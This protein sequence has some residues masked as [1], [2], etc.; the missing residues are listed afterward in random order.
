MLPKELGMLPRNMLWSI[1][2]SSK[3][4]Q[5]PKVLGISPD[6]LFDE[7]SMYMSCVAL[8]TSAGSCPSRLLN[9]NP[10][11]GWNLKDLAWYPTLKIITRKA[12][13]C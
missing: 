3:L 4:S 7:T 10:I 9:D 2:M 5:L 1:S 12:E 11:C 6:S 8:P 13:C